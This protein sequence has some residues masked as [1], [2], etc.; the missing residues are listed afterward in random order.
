MKTFQDLWETKST[1]LKMPIVCKKEYNIGLCLTKNNLV[2]LS[3][4]TLSVTHKPQKTLLSIEKFK[5][6]IFKL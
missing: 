2:L 4:A 3:F 6:Y 1:A 5:F